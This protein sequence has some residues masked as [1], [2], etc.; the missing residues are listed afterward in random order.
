MKNSVK[1]YTHVRKFVAILFIV[2]PCS[3]FVFFS[4]AQESVIS[5]KLENQSIRS[6]F[7]AIEKQSKYIFFYDDALR[8]LLTKRVTLSISSASI[9]AVMNRL[10][11]SSGLTYRIVDKQILISTTNVNNSPQEEKKKGI[12]VT[13]K[14]TDENGLPL[15]G[16]NVYV[17]S[18]QRITTTN[19]EGEYSLLITPPAE[20][21][22]L[23]FSFVG[24]KTVEI[25]IGEKEGTL[26]K[27]VQLFP[28]GQLEELIVT[29]IYTR[30]AEGY[31]GS[32]TT[33]TSDGGEY[34]K[35]RSLRL[36]PGEHGNGLRPEHDSFHVDPWYI[37]LPPGG[38]LLVQE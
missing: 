16:V 3:F 14:V 34:E 38:K 8:P 19:M 5:L 18:L 23:Q 1:N 37:Q 36:Y 28:D 7:D 33:L 26:V 32:A 11:E 2:F 22:L 12:T 25:L 4:N 15:P 17:L 13:G 31:T 10:L 35:S 6:G 24:M 20:P 27:N 21:V 9:Q 29:G 30:K